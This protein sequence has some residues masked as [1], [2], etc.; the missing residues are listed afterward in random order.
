MAYI[1]F[2]DGF[3]TG[4][5]NNWDSETDPTSELSVV[6]SGAH[7]GVFSAQAQLSGNTSIVIQGFAGSTIQYMTCWIKLPALA[8]IPDATY[9]KVTNNSAGGPWDIFLKKD[10]SGEP[11]VMTAYHQ[12]SGSASAAY[13][14]IDNFVDDQNWAFLEAGCEIGGQQWLRWNGQTIESHSCEA[15]ATTNQGIELGNPSGRDWGGEYVS[16]DDFAVW[17][18][19]PSADVEVDT[20]TL[21]AGTAALGISVVVVNDYH[22]ATDGNDGDDGSLGSPWKT[23]AASMPKLTAGDTLYVHEGTYSAALEGGHAVTAAHG[24]DEHRITV[25]PYEGAAVEFSGGTGS[26]YHANRFRILHDYWTIQGIERHHFE[27][28]IYVLGSY[29]TIE[30]CH[31]HTIFFYTLTVESTTGIYVISEDF[32]TNTG[33]IFRNNT[34]ND[35]PAEEGPTLPIGEAIYVGGPANSFVTNFEI[36]GNEIYDC[37]E[38]IDIKPEPGPF[39]VRSNHIHDMKDEPFDAWAIISS[40]NT[41]VGGRG[42]IERNWIENVYGGLQITAKT[43]CWNN[44]LVNSTTYRSRETGIH[45]HGLAT[46]DRGNDN[47]LYNNTAY[48]CTRGIKFANPTL[49]RGNIIKNNICKDNTGWQISPNTDAGFGGGNDN[50]FDYNLIS[51][52]YDEDPYTAGEN[53]YYNTGTPPDPEF[54]DADGGDFRLSVDSIC[55]DNGLDIAVVTDDYNGINRPIGD[56]YDMG[57][58]EYVP[59]AA[60]LSATAAPLNIT[61]EEGVATIE[62]GTAT[63][64]SAALTCSVVASGVIIAAGVANLDVYPKPGFSFARIFPIGG[65]VSVEQATATAASAALAATVEEGGVAPDADLLTAATAAL[66]PTITGGPVEVAASTATAATA[67]LGAT[68][69]IASWPQSI[70]MDLLS[71]DSAALTATVGEGAVSIDADLLTA[72]SAALTPTITGG[73]VTVEVNTCTV[74]SAAPTSAVQQGVVTIDVNTLTAAS[75]ALAT[76]VTGGPTSVEVGAASAEAS[77]LT[78]AVVPSGAIVSLAT[79]SAAASAVSTSVVPGPISVAVDL[80]SA[81]SATLSPLVVPGTVTIN[82]DL[83]A[84]A[85]AALDAA[86]VPGAAWVNVNTLAAA[87]SVLDAVVQ[88]GAV[89]IAVDP[90]TAATATL[91]P[92]LSTPI[93]VTLDLLSAAS[94]AL[95]SAIVGGDASLDLDT[96]IAA[97]DALTAAIWPDGI[98]EQPREETAFVDD[99]PGLVLV[100]RGP[101]SRGRAPRMHRGG[102]VNGA[103]RV[104]PTGRGR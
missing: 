71:A 9:W 17:N 61:V 2:Q 23:F 5:F 79:A 54:L 33:A 32:G 74:A 47:T 60:L 10:A 4:N 12:L 101:R 44:V 52:D 98:V 65:P 25:T 69:S 99:A 77:A 34:F 26:N 87:A 70:E 6:F 31:I 45:V 27:K 73:P 30:D 86:I 19:F 50:E 48:K 28:G 85:S 49:C 53:G 94:A 90:A 18:V 56:D 62:V 102:R 84:A 89:A 41:V 93:Q 81:T 78:M 63:A 100:H 97:S 58:Y 80:L 7:S 13:V 35:I 66:T 20:N 104:G 15:W 14:E 21:S 83:L 11:A 103:G 40:F 88:A 22:M 38:G 39:V 43:D 72:A 55:K 24:A 51:G 76:T 92:T 82:V 95:N 1:K 46:G 64:A 75:A 96:L 8:D 42:L 57:A 3:E 59:V 36:S 29:C 91:S 67:A 16:I 37:A 68:I